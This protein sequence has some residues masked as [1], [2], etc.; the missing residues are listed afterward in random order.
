MSGYELFIHTHTH[1]HT[2]TYIYI[3]SDYVVSLENTYLR[4]KSISV[5]IYTELNTSVY[6]SNTIKLL[7][8]GTFL[9]N[10]TSKIFLFRRCGL[11]YR[12]LVTDKCLYPSDTSEKKK[13]T[14]EHV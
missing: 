11:Y 1:T 13:K 8:L 5:I 14:V 6:F 3:W 9:S 12:K 4:E 10:I 2:H 7:P